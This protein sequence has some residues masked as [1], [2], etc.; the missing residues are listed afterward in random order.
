[1]ELCGYAGSILHV[2]L[3]SGEFRK[4][5]LDPELARKYLGG[6]GINHKLYYDL[7]PPHVAPLSPDNPLIVGTGPF[8]GTIIPGSSRTYITHK[9]P[10]SGT[11]G[12]AVGT[13][14]FSNM[15]KS[16]GYDHIVITGKARKPVYL[17]ISEY[18][19]ELCDASELWGK[20]TYDT[21]FALRSK[22][23]PC[24]IIAIG[25]AGENLVSISVTHVDSLT[26]ADYRGQSMAYLSVSQHIPGS[27]R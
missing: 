21:V 16:A 26:P 11:I 8:P 2:N 1:M 5:P 13:G 10:L 20:D 17:R 7:T 9:H 4:E 14:V 18:G 23:E 12:S 19:T 15:L 22:Y 3:T 24:S 6:W 25:P 27:V